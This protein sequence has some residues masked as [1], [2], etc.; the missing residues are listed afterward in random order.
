M[1]ESTNASLSPDGSI[2]SV[3]VPLNL[4]K[5]GGRKLIIAPAGTPEP[6]YN[7]PQSKADPTLVKAL[8]RAHRWK[9]LLDSRRYATIKEIAETEKVHESYVGNLL[10]LTLLAPD[11]IEATLDGRLPKGIGL[12]DFMKPWPGTW[13]DQRTHLQ[14]LG[15]G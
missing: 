11:I 10:R 3:F 5:R 15:Q 6:V 4:R 14:T 8:A 9:R 12:A 2:L 13:E 1:T 7:P